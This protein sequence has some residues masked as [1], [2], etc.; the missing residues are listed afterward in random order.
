MHGKIQNKTKQKQTIK[1]HTQT[2]T[3]SG[4]IDAVGYSAT[5]Y[6]KKRDANALQ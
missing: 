2:R 1:Q 6:T 4:K 3:N 5:V